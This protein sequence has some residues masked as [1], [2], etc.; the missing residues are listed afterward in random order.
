M[1]FRTLKMK[2]AFEGSGTGYNIKPAGA[3]LM[4]ALRYMSTQD[5]FTGQSVPGDFN[6]LSLNARLY[7]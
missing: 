6:K 1:G 4:G 7:I 5:F 3:L 2:L